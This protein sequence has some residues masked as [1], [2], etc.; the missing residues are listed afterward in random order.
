MCMIINLQAGLRFMVSSFYLSLVTAEV[1]LDLSREVSRR[2]LRTSVAKSE[3]LRS[4]CTS[5]TMRIYFTHLIISREAN[6]SRTAK[7][8]DTWEEVSSKHRLEIN[9]SRWWIAHTYRHT[10]ARA[11]IYIL[12]HVRA[13][14]NY[15]KG[16]LQHTCLDKKLYVYSIIVEKVS[17]YFRFAYTQRRLI[18]LIM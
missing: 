14:H 1:N 6:C 10:H 8:A 4:S 17:N 11:H 15:E 7:C 9:F 18:H 12:H 3:E 16:Q 13:A 5:R 2:W